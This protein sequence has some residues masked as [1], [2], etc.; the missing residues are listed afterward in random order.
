MTDPFELQNAYLRA[1][2][3]LAEV[4]E[5]IRAS[6]FD[7]LLGEW[8]AESIDIADCLLKDWQDLCT[9]MDKKQGGWEGK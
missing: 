9:E 1:C 6:P 2:I 5:A 3:D 7:P 4:Q 8:E